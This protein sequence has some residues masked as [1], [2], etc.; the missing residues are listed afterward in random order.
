MTVTLTP[1]VVVPATAVATIWVSLQLFTVGPVPLKAM[2]L[3]PL[4]AWNPEPLTVTCVPTAPLVGL[5]PVTWGPG[6]VKNTFVL[7]PMPPTVTF[8]AP[9]VA[10]VGTVAVI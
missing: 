9:V 5:M 8:T 1:P 7:P 3:E 2:E 10:A 4:V 6:T